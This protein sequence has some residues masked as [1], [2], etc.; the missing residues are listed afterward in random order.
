MCQT[1]LVSMVAIYLHIRLNVLHKSRL[2]TASPVKTTKKTIFTDI[3]AKSEERKRAKAD[4]K[5]KK[6][7]VA[8]SEVD[9]MGMHVLHPSNTVHC[10]SCNVCLSVIECESVVKYLN[11]IIDNPSPLS[12]RR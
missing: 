11:R 6:Y 7:E 10:N 1:H 5:N 9:T 12:F 2:L 3:N 4:A 8:K